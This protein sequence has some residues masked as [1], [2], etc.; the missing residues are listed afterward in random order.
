M[1]ELQS[2]FALIKSKAESR[3]SDLEAALATAEKFWENLNGM[4][5]T[6][7]ELQDTMT[8][9]DHPA[10]EPEMIRDQ[11]DVIEVR[12][13][14]TTLPGV[15]Q[16]GSMSLYHSRQCCNITGYDDQHG[17]TGTEARYDERRTLQP[18]TLFFRHSP[19]P[20]DNWI[21]F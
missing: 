8:T 1:S 6:L 9:T 16:V 14:D 20:D 13:P 15:E 17:L 3:Q 10:L 4:L 21:H 18:Q 11:Q 12:I 19:R 5:A 2:T 7:K